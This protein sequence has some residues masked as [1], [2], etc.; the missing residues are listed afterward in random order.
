[1]AK[2][3]IIEPDIT[4]EENIRNWKRVEEII[5]II[6]NEVRKRDEKELDAG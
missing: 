6:V 3:I 2:V 1:M 5:N 4:P